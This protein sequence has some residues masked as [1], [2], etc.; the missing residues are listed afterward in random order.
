MQHEV[1]VHGRQEHTAQEAAL[2]SQY[3]GAPALRPQAQRQTPREMLA[4]GLRGV[5]TRGGGDPSAAVAG[6]G[7]E[8]FSA[9]DVASLAAAAAVA[10]PGVT[11]PRGLHAQL[12]VSLMRT[13]SAAA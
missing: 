1:H 11:R 8:P 4:A 12:C 7:G 3:S 9:P 5:K 6:G 2:L 10:P 13:P